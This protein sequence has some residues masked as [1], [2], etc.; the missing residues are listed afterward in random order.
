MSKLIV[1]SRGLIGQR[2]FISTFYFNRKSIRVILKHTAV[3]VK[4]N[5]NILRPYS[6]K[7][8]IFR[9]FIRLKIPQ[10]IAIRKQRPSDKSITCSIRFFLG[11]GKI[12]APLNS[13]LNYCAIFK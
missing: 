11:L 3:S 12:V 1:L 4:Y 7:R 2:K 10:L 5:I 8:Y 6:I 13:Y 9:Y